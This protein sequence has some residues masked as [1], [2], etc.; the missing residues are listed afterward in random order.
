MGSEV[1]NINLTRNFGVVFD[2]SGYNYIY[3]YIILGKD[4]EERE[5]LIK[6]GEK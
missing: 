4:A 6:E 1:K 2:K 3:F 5:I